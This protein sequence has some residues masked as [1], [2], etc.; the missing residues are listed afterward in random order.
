MGPGAEV[1][2]GTAG[3][4]GPLGLADGPTM[5]DEK[6]SD[7]GPPLPRNDPAELLLDFILFVA[8]GET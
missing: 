5:K 1:M 6:M 4:G 7:E 8:P 2:D 3:A